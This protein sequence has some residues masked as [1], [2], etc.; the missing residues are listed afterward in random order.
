MKLCKGINIGDHFEVR[1]KP[2]EDF[3]N[4]VGDY[5][6][7]I[8]KDLGFDHIRL[9]VRW[10]L[11]TRDE[12]DYQIEAFFL[13]AVTHTVKSALDNG[14]TLILNVHH[15][16]EMSEDA[17][18]N[19]EKLF[20]IWEQLSFVYK[21]YPQELIFEVMNEPQTGVDSGLWNEIQNCCVEIIRKTNPTRKIMIG[22]TFWNSCEG[23]VLLN[24][25]PDENLIATFHF[26]EPHSFTH[27]GARWSPENYGFKDVQWLG[28]KEERAYVTNVLTK[29]KNWA[30]EHHMPVN[31][32]EFGAY[33]TGD[34]ASRARWTEHVRKEA[35]RL[36]ISFTYWEFCHGFGIY[37]KATKT[38]RQELVQALLG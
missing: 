18:G 13:D 1:R 27:Q 10:S 32:G 37:D 3:I 19:K 14:F 11:Y 30:E 15:F 38:F 9:P 6:F 29:A 5:Y 34:M 24:P 33:S 21:D 4:P 35:E 28:T 36:G 12:D 2:G 25:V 26:Y 7:P 20:A 17:L 8:I 31:M 23:L 16:I 22:G